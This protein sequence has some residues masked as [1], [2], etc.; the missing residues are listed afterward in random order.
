[1]TVCVRG[2]TVTGDEPTAVKH[3]RRA[4]KRRV[5]ERFV[6][7]V[8]TRVDHRD[9]DAGAIKCVRKEPAVPDWLTSDKTHARGLLEV[10]LHFDLTVRRDVVDETALRKRIDG[11]DR[12]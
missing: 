8:D 12:Q 7:S 1:M 11:R 9:P 2:R 5:S 6:S 3:A 10:A 4:E